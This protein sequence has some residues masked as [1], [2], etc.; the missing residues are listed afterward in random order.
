[1]V[2]PGVR[3]PQFMVLRGMVHALSE[4]TPK[5][6]DVVTV[7]EEDTLVDV[8]MTAKVVSDKAIPI[9]TNATTEVVIDSFRFAVIISHTNTS[10]SKS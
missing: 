6:A 9:M 3:A 5:F 10:C 8:V 1:M 7:P 4:Y 2:P